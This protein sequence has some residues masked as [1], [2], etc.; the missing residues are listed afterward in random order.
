MAQQLALNLRLRDGAVFEGYYPGDNGSAVLTLE[1]LAGGGGET[2]V[3]VWGAPQTGKS[4]LL[5]A[6]CHRA[7]GLG[8][9]SAYLPLAGFGGDAEVLRDL[10][11]VEVLALD[12]VEAVIGQSAWERA[13]FNVINASRERGHRL[14]FASRVNPV[15]LPVAL[16]D[17]A[18]RLLW[19]PVF[20]LRPL[21][22]EA[23]LAAL[24]RRASRRGFELP[25]EAARY[26]LRRHPRDLGYLLGLLDAIDAATLA[27]QRRATLPFI[28]RVLEGP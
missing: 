16:P 14:V 7:T 15:H 20:H 3:Y 17:L 22:D 6:V 11:R 25:E 8:L 1:R 10:E 26:M 18:S 5:Q 12:D 2:Q 24:T 28:R 4:H 9:A 19:G 13:L 21:D 23:K 27:A